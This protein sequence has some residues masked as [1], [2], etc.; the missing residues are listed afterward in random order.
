MTGTVQPGAVVLVE[1]PE[2]HPSGHEQEG[3]R[4]AVILSIPQATRFPV[5]MVLPMTTADGAW[6]KRG[7]DAYLQLAKGQG[8]IKEPSV[9]L[10]DQLRA[11]GPERVLRIWGDLPA[12]S[13]DR[14]K[15]RVRSFLSL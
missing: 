2:H 4:P 13:F 3:R 10:L 15:A 6:V 11:I 12:E 1:F 5:V 14:I 7:K 9:L 8:G